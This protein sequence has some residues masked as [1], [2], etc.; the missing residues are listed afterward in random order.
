[1]V[2]DALSKAEG[3]ASEGSTAGLAT[4]SPLCG[5][6][7]NSLD[8]ASETATAAALQGDIFS[9]P[10]SP[11]AR[12][13][14]AS[15]AE[16]FVAP[17]RW[18]SGGKKRAESPANR[19]PISPPA[20]APAPASDPEPE[21]APAPASA[22][23]AHV[24]V[25]AQPQQRASA[26]RAAGSALGAAVAEQRFL[27]LA[28]Q[29]DLAVLM[30]GPDNEV[31]FANAAARRVFG[32]SVSLADGAIFPHPL[33]QQPSGI[34]EM[35]DAGGVRLF[36]ADISGTWWKDHPVW[37]ACVRPLADAALPKHPEESAAQTLPPSTEDLHLSCFTT[38]VLFGEARRQALAL[39]DL[40]S[41]E[42]Q[43][44][45]AS[46]PA[47]MLCADQVQL[48]R[49]LAY[50]LANGLR[51][52]RRRV[53]F[54]IL[55]TT[56]Q[57]LEFHITDDGPGFSAEA[58]A[59]FAQGPGGDAAAASSAKPTGLSYAAH[60][61]ARHDGALALFSPAGAPAHLAGRLPVH[62]LLTRPPALVDPLKACALH[63][64]HHLG[65]PENE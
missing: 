56:A 2:M 45:I 48:G 13:E 40:G 36:H 58:F 60:I 4:A 34:F 54:S 29:C 63:H 37:M 50:L 55:C 39:A 1:M 41:K 65:K 59:A 22:T 64:A 28:A 25:P 42:V 35:A 9:P 57:M 23:G 52:A 53:T 38:T 8:I 12:G 33:A 19:P 20:S 43:I 31:R 14:S 27:S 6:Q 26:G 47:L 24:V 30:L 51:Y 7:A 49:A 32:A 44:H 10:A 11:G 18:R 21:A 15:A 3:G 46:L 16:I 62:C 17:A 5:T 61:F